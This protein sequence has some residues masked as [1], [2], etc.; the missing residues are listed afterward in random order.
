L[1][2]H[3]LSVSKEQIIFNP[4]LELDQNQQQQFFSLIE[5][6]SR[7]EP[8]SQIIGKREFFGQDF[9]VTHNVLDP[10]PDSESLVELVL[11]KFPNKNQKLE[12]L[13]IGT[14]SGCLIITL[15]LLYKS[16]RG[17]GVD[18]SSAALEICKKNSTTHQINDRL[19]LQESD[20]FLS[21]NKNKKFDLI[22]SNPPYIASQEIE[23]LEVEVKKF[24]PRIALD[25]GLD[26]LNFYRRI[27]V[28]AQDFLLENGRIILEIGFGQKD[29]IVKIFTENNF[30]FE[31]LKHDLAGVERA[32]SFESA[33]KIA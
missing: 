1:L 25:G 7:R 17:N 3:A 12:I 10:R 5:R 14:G 2:T 16:A 32:L 4:N 30:V 13:E 19:D 27:A 6:R 29:E 21:L 8:V 31:E 33:V 23:N 22:I 26:G 15:L 20:L 18:I 24:E 9:L 11:K 28:K